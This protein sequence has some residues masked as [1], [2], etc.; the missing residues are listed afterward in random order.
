MILI[1]V[2]P[3]K[4][5]YDL[6]NKVDET[7][8]IFQISFSLKLI[9]DYITSLNKFMDREEPW[10]SFKNNPKKT[11]KD[12]AILIEGFRLIGIILQPFIPN[13]SSKILD[14]ININKNLRS[15][16]YLN[17]DHK[18]QKGHLINEP[19]PIFPRYETKDC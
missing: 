3:L 8:K 18:I 13:A 17:K 4:D 12:L 15:F 9:F 10:N 19:K 11:G 2:Q 14:T 1:Q 16:K 5:G 6:L 7:M